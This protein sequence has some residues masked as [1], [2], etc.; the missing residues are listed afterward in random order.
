MAAAHQPRDHGDDP[1]A[2][3]AAP[4]DLPHARRSCGDSRLCQS[5]QDI[6]LQ[7]LGPS[8]EKSEEKCPGDI[9]REHDGP[10]A[11]CLPHMAPLHQ[12]QRHWVERVFREQLPAA[13]DHRHESHGVKQ[14]RHE[15]RPRRWAQQSADH[16]DAEAG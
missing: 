14:Q 4:E 15:L 16:G 8:G 2:H 5:M 11:H 1:A 7:R 9:G 12:N 10:Q 3:H 13:K 6:R